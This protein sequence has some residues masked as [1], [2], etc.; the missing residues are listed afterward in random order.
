MARRL[1]RAIVKAIDASGVLGIRAGK[2][3]DHRFIGIWPVVVGRRV[4]VRSWQQKAG[5]WYRTFVEDPL[6]A[7]QLPAIVPSA[8][9]PCA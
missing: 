5:G 1:S 4:F 7:I 6:G 2:N 8:S 9:E 3:S